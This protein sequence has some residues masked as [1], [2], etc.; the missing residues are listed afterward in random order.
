M[1]HRDCKPKEIYAESHTVRFRFAQSWQPPG[2]VARA[3][4]A[5]QHAFCAPALPRPCR[6][7]RPSL[8]PRCLQ[9]PDGDSRPGFR[10][11]GADEPRR[12]F[13]STTPQRLPSPNERLLAGVQES[14]ERLGVGAKREAP[15]SRAP[16]D[17][18]H[19]RPLP[20]FAGAAAAAVMSA[21]LWKA[22]Q[23][24]VDVY[25]EHPF[26]S[27]VYALNRVTAVVR[28]AV[29]GLLA[30]ASGISGVTAAGLA[31]LGGQVTVETLTGKKSPGQAP[32][33]EE[34]GTE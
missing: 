33:D 5:L 34:K 8:S 14:M 30:L 25:V 24:A 12:S 28:T 13:R 10:Q 22:L 6:T 18:S 3:G 17:Y 4:M 11:A 20:A 21:A 31:L 16:A 27:D 2:P 19:V 23:M 15:P 32:A 9:P 1:E 26:V 29:V 7:R